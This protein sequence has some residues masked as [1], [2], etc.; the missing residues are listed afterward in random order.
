[1]EINMLVFCETKLPYI[2]ILWNKIGL[3]YYFVIQKKHLLLL[4]SYHYIAKQKL[5]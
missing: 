4:H 2:T 1:M 5:A 3:Y